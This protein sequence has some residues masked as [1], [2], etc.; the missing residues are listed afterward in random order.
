MTL[1][2]LNLLSFFLFW[3]WGE[4][5][6]VEE[7]KPS[8]KADGGGKGAEDDEEEG[9]KRCQ[10]RPAREGAGCSYSSCCLCWSALIYFL[11]NTVKTFNLCSDI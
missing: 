10:G 11:R 7:G 6:G 3:G 2:F 4:V 1:V 5:I 8:P 9:G